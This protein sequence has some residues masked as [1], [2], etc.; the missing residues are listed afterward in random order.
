MNHQQHD[1]DD[2]QNPRDFRRDDGN[3]RR[4]EDTGHETH[5]QEYKRVIKHWSTSLSTRTEAEDVPS[6]FPNKTH[7]S[8]SRCRSAVLKS[9][10]RSVRAAAHEDMRK[11]LRDG[12]AIGTDLEA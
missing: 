6:I 11:V 1:A 5:N 4:A 8:M 7:K 9:D 3:A 12:S 10:I 2:E